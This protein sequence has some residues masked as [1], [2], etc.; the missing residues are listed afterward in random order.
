[1]TGHEHCYERIHPNV[2]GKVEM[3]GNVYN[4]PKYPVY[5]V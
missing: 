2:N 1:M 5:I 4:N 3:T